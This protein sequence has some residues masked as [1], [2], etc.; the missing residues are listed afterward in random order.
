LA[1]EHFLYIGCVNGELVVL[2]L[3]IEDP[4][5]LI[6]PLKEDIYKLALVG[7]R[8]YIAQAFGNLHRMITGHN[9]SE[10]EVPID[11]GHI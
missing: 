1:Y 11:T 4:I 10:L 9:L 7:D 5:P 3:S 2:D 8:L 6:L